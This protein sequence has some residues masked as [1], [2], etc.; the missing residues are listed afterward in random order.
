[1]AASGLIS[2][3]LAYGTHASRPVTPNVG[4]GV[5]SLYYETD[6]TNTFAWSGS[7][8]VQVN[9]AGGG[10]G[11]MTQIADVNLTGGSQ[12]TISFSSIAGTYN[13]LLLKWSL[14]TTSVNNLDKFT[15]Q[16]NGDTGANYQSVGQI[17]GTTDTGLG[18]TD[19]ANSSATIPLGRTG[20]GTSTTSA[21]GIGESFLNDYANTNKHKSFRSNDQSPYDATHTYNGIWSGRWANTAAITSILITPAAGSFA[22]YS[23]VTLYGII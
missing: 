20:G 15:V 7:A 18:V 1:M 2:S 9:S 13:H 12:A 16:F 19:S 17:G 8:W 23:R 22:Q 4:T 5:T 11:A 21:F 10:A 14:R 6:T 3:Y